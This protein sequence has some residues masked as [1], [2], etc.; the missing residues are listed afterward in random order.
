MNANSQS[1]NGIV[2]RLLDVAIDLQ[3]NQA[4]PK[5]PCSASC[6]VNDRETEHPDR[7]LE[8]GL[9]AVARRMLRE[10]DDRARHFDD[11][12]FS[13]PAWH[14]ILDLY[15]HCAERRQVSVT[16]ACVASRVPPT[17]GLRWIASL[18]DQGVVEKVQDPQDRRRFHVSLS[19]PAFEAMSRY[20]ASISGIETVVL[21]SRPA[22]LR[23]LYDLDKR[24]SVGR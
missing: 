4:E 1:L 11:E 6:P 12:L 15:A 20:L 23:S 9:A 13:D 5:E 2:A 16:D 7:S 8:T 19:Q 21:P 10:A 22:P 24:D 14:I 3:R 18:I 17:T